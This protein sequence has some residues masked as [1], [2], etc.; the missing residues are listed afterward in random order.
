MCY[1]LQ[2]AIPKGRAFGPDFFAHSLLPPNHHSLLIKPGCR[3]A[4]PSCALCDGLSPCADGVD[5]SLEKAQT[6]RLIAC[7]QIYSIP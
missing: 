4:S 7:P 5:L 6:A 3:T 2:D 1:A